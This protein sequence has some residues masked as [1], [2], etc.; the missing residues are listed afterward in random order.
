MA[1]RG[2][3]IV[4]VAYRDQN[5]CK[6]RGAFGRGTHELGEPAFGEG[7][8]RQAGERIVIHVMGDCRFALGDVALHRVEGSRKTAEFVSAG[9]LHRRAVLTLLNTTGCQNQLADRTRGTP[10][11]ETADQR[12]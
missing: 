2:V 10:A 12:S 5:E 7:A 6:A 11:E 4:D 3:D 9:D 1:E 8:I